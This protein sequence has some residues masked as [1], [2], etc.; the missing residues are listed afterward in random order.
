MSEIYSN[1]PRVR[2]EDLPLFNFDTQSLSGWLK[3][4]AGQQST[5]SKGKLFYIIFN[6]LFL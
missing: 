6:Y 2:V 3:K 1:L 4:Q 5:F